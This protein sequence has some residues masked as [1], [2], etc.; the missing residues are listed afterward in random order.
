V[1]FQIK[2]IGAGMKNKMLKRNDGMKL[3]TYQSDGQESQ[4][5]PE[6][7]SLVNLKNM[8]LLAWGMGKRQRDAVVL[9]QQQ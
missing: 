5:L 2:V 1:L 4:K 6:V 3:M 9:Y 7:L 8:V